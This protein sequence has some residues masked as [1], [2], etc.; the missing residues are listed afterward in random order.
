APIAGL[1]GVA[2]GGGAGPVHETDFSAGLPAT[3]SAGAIFE[4]FTFGRFATVD[5]VALARE[6]YRTRPDNY[7]FLVV[8]TDFPANIGAVAF[9]AG[10]SNRTL[11]LGLPVYAATPFFGTAGDL[12][13]L[14]RRNNS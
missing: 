2:A 5:F 10:V 11:G 9:N 8:F 12:A 7:D 3:V 1:V 13:S 14:W 4:E 6:F